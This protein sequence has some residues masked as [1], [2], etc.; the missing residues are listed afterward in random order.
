MAIDMHIKKSKQWQALH[1]ILFVWGLDNF[2]NM[3]ISIYATLRQILEEL[4][5]QRNIFLANPKKPCF[6]SN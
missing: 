6:C 4:A 1:G 5:G 2:L 3:L